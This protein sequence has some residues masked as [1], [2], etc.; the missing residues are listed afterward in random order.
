MDLKLKNKIK[1]L[2]LLIVTVVFLISGC[3][4]ELNPIQNTQN[5]DYTLKIHFLDVGQ[6]DSILI[7][8]DTAIM[9]IDAGNNADED[10][11]VSYLTGRGIQK[12]DYLIGTHPHE[13]HIG[14]FDSIIEKFEID[15]IYLPKVTH[16]SKSF[17]DVLA[18]IKN[19]GLKIS[20]PEV[21][22]NFKLDDSNCTFL[23]PV[24]SKYENLNN[25]SI[26]I[27]LEHGDNSFLFTGDAEEISEKEM[28]E[29]PV[30]LTADVLKLGHHGSSSSTSAAFLDQVKPKYA[31][32]SCEKGN[33]YGHPHKKTM[34]RLKNRTIKVYRTDESGTI[35]CSS[36]GK[37]I[38]FNVE[39]GG[40]SSGK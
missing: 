21:G 3:Q 36:D 19:K 1:F 24:S 34:E 29:L 7:E 40:Y 8:S 39:P 20:I 23:A 18:A 28:I 33:D 30:D 37:N 6:A 38:K 9:L 32:L 31:V 15:K 26:V 10:L 2:L 22:N 25:Y 13:D 17:A 27:K 12:I 5:N 11:I 14:A 35:I 16:T 4:A